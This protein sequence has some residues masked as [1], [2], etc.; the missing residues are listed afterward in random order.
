MF[1]NTYGEYDAELVRIAM[2]HA[3]ALVGQHGYTPDDAD[4]ILQTLIIAGI[5]ALSRF[6]PTKAMRSTYLYSTIRDKALDLARRADS[7]KRDRR[8]ERCSLNA[9]WPEDETGETVWADVIGIENTIT[10]DGSPR[11]DLGDLQ[12][13]KMDLAEALASLPPKLRALCCFHAVLDSEDAR[14][15]A[16]MAYSTH[17]RAIRQ[18]RAYLEKKGFAP[19]KSGRDRASITDHPEGNL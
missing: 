12:G 4:D 15:A 11:K 18:I 19:K 2:A 5:I 7:Q 6:D 3:A 8:K 14:R 10:E 17:H 16:G 1:N 9:E 13:L